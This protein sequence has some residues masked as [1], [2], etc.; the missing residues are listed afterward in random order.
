MPVVTVGA[1][2]TTEEGA[3][4]SPPVSTTCRTVFSKWQAGMEG[5]T[6]GSRSTSLNPSLCLAG[7]NVVPLMIMMLI[8][9][10][11]CGIH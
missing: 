7:Y 10:M 6:E 9:I 8:L 5:T 11:P 2:V 3:G 1:R 4:W